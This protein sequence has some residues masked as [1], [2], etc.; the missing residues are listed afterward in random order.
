MSTPPKKAKSSSKNKPT[1]N[2][3]KNKTLRHSAPKTKSVDVD[4]R[5]SDRKEE[6]TASPVEE[7]VMRSEE[8]ELRYLEEE[9]RRLEK[10]NEERKKKL[11]QLMAE[12]KAM[13]AEAGKGTHV[14]CWR[15]FS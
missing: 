13:L 1:T 2:G 11:E 14:C 9:R 5:S 4:K 3:T 15:K 8:D 10:E 7:R 6:K 12:E